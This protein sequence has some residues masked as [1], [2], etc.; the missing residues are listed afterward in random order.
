MFS[1]FKKVI[2]NLLLLAFVVSTEAVATVREDAIKSG[3]LYNFALYSH[4]D[5][6]NPSLQS[7]YNLCS[8][9]P[10]F[11]D[12][13]KNTLKGLTIENRPVVVNLL[14]SATEDS[15]ECHTLFVTKAD[16]DKWNRLMA[17][18]RLSQSM[19]VGEFQSFI[20]S[21]GHISFF[22]VGGKVRFEIDPVKLKQAGINM[23][24]KVLRLG[25]MHQGGLQ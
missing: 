17:K 1:L 23:S 24:S 14:T 9:N 16:V 22:I 3:F 12:V 21:G 6:F 15:I 19:L 11:I 2:L 8:F 4:G 7:Y 18:G 5:W 20:T 13:A 25:R 10:H